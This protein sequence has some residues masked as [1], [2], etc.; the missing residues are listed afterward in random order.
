[1]WRFIVLA[2]LIFSLFS[3]GSDFSKKN[4][5]NTYNLTKRYMHRPAEQ[6]YNTA[7]D[8]YELKNLVNDPVF[9]D[10]KSSLSAELDRWMKEQG[11][12]GIRQDTHEALQAAR[13]GKH[14]YGAMAR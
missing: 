13:R 5:P 8:P 2:C 6:L 4:N 1:M 14:L 9:S 11:D 12:P 7:E 3:C 10:I